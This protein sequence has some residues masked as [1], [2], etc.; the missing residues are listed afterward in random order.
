MLVLNLLL[1]FQ[2]TI[3]SLNHITGIPLSNATTFQSPAQLAYEAG[4]SVD[5]C[6][7]VPVTQIMSTHD[8]DTNSSNGQRQ[9]QVQ[10]QEQIAFL[11]KGGISDPSKMNMLVQ[12]DQ[13]ADEG[14]DC[15]LVFYTGLISPTEARN[16]FVSIFNLDENSPTYHASWSDIASF[17]SCLGTWQVCGNGTVE[18]IFNVN[19]IPCRPHLCFLLAVEQDEA[20]P[21]MDISALIRDSLWVRYDCARRYNNTTTSPKTALSIA[22]HDRR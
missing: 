14:C 17:G 4:Y 12:F 10:E 15:Q 21:N 5:A 22:G 8:M 16:I 2:F 9:E 20:T 6:G 11:R 1:A 13:V 3:S 7:M 18:G 19:S